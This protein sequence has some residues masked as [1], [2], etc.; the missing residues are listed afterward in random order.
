VSDSAVEAES[1]A[2][3]DA[4]TRRIVA[5]LESLVRIGFLA[6][7]ELPYPQRLLAARFSRLSPAGEDGIFGM[8]ATVCGLLTGACCVELGLPPR[9]RGT[10]LGATAM[11]LGFRYLALDADEH[12][13]QKAQLKLGSP[14]LQFCKMNPTVEDLPDGLLS[15]GIDVLAIG[16]EWGGATRWERLAAFRPTIVAVAYKVRLGLQPVTIVGQGYESEPRPYDARLLGSSL[17]AATNVANR[18][19]YRLAVV[20]PDGHVAFFVKDGVAPEIQAMDVEVAYAISR[21]RVDAN[22]A[23]ATIDRA[24]ARGLEVRQAG[25]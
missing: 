10:L 23:A 18:Q 2:S 19:R 5:K 4:P 15:G 25:M 21:G 6:S 17:T 24:R 7:A 1:P 22:L 14:N 3:G 9:E 13:L 8:L 20:E 12:R 16:N 11:E